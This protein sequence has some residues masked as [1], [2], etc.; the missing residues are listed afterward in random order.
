[1]RVPELL[2]QPS[3]VG[4]DQA[5]LP[6]IIMALLKGMPEDV[7]EEVAAGGLLLTGGN[8]SFEGTWGI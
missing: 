7:A 6:E 1:V 5:G 8:A 2:F 3:L 4:V